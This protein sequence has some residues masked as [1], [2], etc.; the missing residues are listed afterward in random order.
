LTVDDCRAAAE[1]GTLSEHILPID[2]AFAEYPAVEVTAPQ[3]V[4]FQNGGELFADRIQNLPQNARD[5]RIYH[6]NGT[7]V[8]LGRTDE[9]YVRVVRIFSE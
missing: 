5:V 4:R 9:E 8:G 3:A 2:S 7:F 6:P 1:N